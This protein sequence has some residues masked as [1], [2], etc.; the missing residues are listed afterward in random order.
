MADTYAYLGSGLI[1]PFRRD[2]KDDFAHASG[3]E[4]VAQTVL[5]ILAT[6]RAGPKNVGEVPF[7][8]ELGT[9]LPTLRHRNIN[10]PTTEELAR[11]YTVDSLT[12][13]EPRIRPKGVGFIPRPDKNRLAVRLRYDLV[14]RGTSGINVVARDIEE[15]FDL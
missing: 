2:G 15:E 3:E 12:D 9:L 6:R 5:V 1:A 13:N 8:Q 14:E 10:D 4:L 7:N 11:H